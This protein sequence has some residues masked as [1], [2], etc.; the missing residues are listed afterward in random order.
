[1]RHPG[2][3]WKT[4]AASIVVVGTNVAGNY[5]LRRGLEEVGVLTSWSPL[6]YI[7]TFAHPWIAIGVLFMIAWL[8][9]RL[10]LLSWA[11]LTYVLPVTSVSYALTALVGAHYLN[12]RVSGLHWTAIAIITAGVALVVRTDPETTDT[13][14]QAA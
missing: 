9:S 2:L 11:D 5:G 6:D 14:E 8:A 12:E 13:P 1:M 4:V 7:R 10:A 3:I